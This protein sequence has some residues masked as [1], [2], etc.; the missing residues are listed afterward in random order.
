LWL[1]REIVTD[2]PLPWQQPLSVESI[3]PGRV[4]QAFSAI[5]A[6]IGTPAQPP[7][8]RGKSPGWTQDKKRPKKIRDPV[9]KKRPSRQRK[10]QQPAS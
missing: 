4:A 9:V 8:P 5:L 6:V 10:N 2:H 1:G 3:T 7:K